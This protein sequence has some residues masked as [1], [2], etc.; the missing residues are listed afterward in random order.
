MSCPMLREA[1]QNPTIYPEPTATVELRETHISLVF[2]T[3]HFAYKI[4]KPVDLGFL[5]FSTLKQRRF[6]C[7]Q[8]LALNRRLSSNVYLAVVPIHLAG[9]AY[10]FDNHGPIVEYAVKMR[11]LSE[12]RCL[13]ALLRRPALIES[14]GTLAQRLAAFHAQ[15]PLP[16]T[17]E[18]YGTLAQVEA[19]WQENFAQ[20]TAFIDKTISQQIHV[21]IQQAVTSFISRHTKWFAQR[22]QE[23]HIRDCHGDLR[24]E[25]IYLEENG[26]LQ[27]IDCIE[28]NE[29]FRFI[30][31]AS[32]VAF[33]TVD[34]ER[35]GVPSMAHRFVQA[36]VQHSGDVTLYRLLNF[37]RCYRAYVRGKV[38]SIR[39]QEGITPDARLP[40]QRQAD[41]YFRLAARYAEALT[42]PL[43]LLTT[44]LIGSGK[45]TVA[46]AMAEGLDLQMHS[47]DRVRKT[48]AGLSPQ[49]PRHEVYGAGLYDASATHRTYEALSER[50]RQALI[51]GH[52]VILDASFSK[53]AERQRMQ[54]LAHE[55]GAEYC[56]LE[57]TAP[58]E[59]L[60]QRLRQREKGPATVS[61]AREEILAQFQRDYDPVQRNETT[62]HIRLD[63]TQSIALCL[64]QALAEIYGRPP[65]LDA[66]SDGV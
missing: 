47:S 11:R 37:Y 35:L 15:H 45:S 49:T 36:Y 10:V 22:A 27:I 41:A 42:R 8:E 13:E 63:T 2:L 38:A 57:C 30:D 43:L 18:P 20:T 3:D 61:D 31:V 29:R 26:Q 34:L 6:Y 40:W 44:G 65:E 56:V 39:L 53:R 19:D 48:L 51:H 16:P 23:G 59:V 4:K 46:T 7:Q 28:F 54:A 50:A 14:M 24:A 62:C 21:R 17:R 5:N 66:E 60:R 32:E 12:D 9:H 25:H 55:V 33:L 52:S 64:Q 58:E 1:L